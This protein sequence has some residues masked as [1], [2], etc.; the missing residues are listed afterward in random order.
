MCFNTV[1][2]ENR[3]CY[4][5]GNYNINLLNY[6]VHSSTAMM[7]SYS[8]MPLINHP[9]RITRDPATIIDNVFTSNLTSLEGSLHGILVTDISDQFLVFHGSPILNRCDIEIKAY[10]RNYSYRNKRAFIEA[11]SE[12]DWSE[13]NFI[14]DTQTAFTRF[15][16]KFVNLYN[17]HFQKRRVC[18]RCNNRD[19]WLTDSLKQSIRK[20]NKL[21]KMYLKI[22][23]VQNELTY[24][25]YRNKLH[26]ILKVAEKKYY[27]NESNLKKTWNILKGMI[28]RNKSSRI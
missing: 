17:K 5:L 25:S 4:I 18:T 3:W 15:Y 21:Y 7:S 28:N 19:P 27:A 14:T 20:K 9:T 22:K 12:T 26:H 6:D 8:F 24:K 2:S 23:S 1:K 11:I 13:I 10:K 16:S